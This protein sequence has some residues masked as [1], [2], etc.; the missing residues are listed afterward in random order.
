MLFR[1]IALNPNAWETIPDATWTPDTSTYAF[2]RGARRP[3]ESMNFSRNFRVK[4]RYTMQVR[5]E[6]TNI[7]NRSF[8]PA[9]SVGFVPVN[10]AST[11]QTAG[12]RYIAGFGTFGNLRNAGALAGGGNLGLGTS[13]R[14]GQ[15]VVRI[16]F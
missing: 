7:F 8:L 11:L 13:Q 10:T 5:M 1:S 16:S 15:L 3:S 6:F 12:G 9:P 2:F 14:T 4:E